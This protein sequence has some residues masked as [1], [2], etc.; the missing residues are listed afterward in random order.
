MAEEA[1]MSKTALVLDLL[2][3]LLHR[4]TVAEKAN[5]VFVDAQYRADVAALAMTRKH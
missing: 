5:S 3:D 4:L 1:N 2:H